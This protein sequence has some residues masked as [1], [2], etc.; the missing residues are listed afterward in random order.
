M[1]YEIDARQSSGEKKIQVRK[2]IH[3]FEEFKDAG[4]SSL[5][6]CRLNREFAVVL[7]FRI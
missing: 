4:P 3:L 2:E 5:L 1:T 6:S 7:A